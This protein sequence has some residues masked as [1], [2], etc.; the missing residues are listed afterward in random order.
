MVGFSIEREENIMEI[1]IC[2]NIKYLRKKAKMTQEELALEMG[3]SRQSLAKWENGESL[4]DVMNCVK[5]SE[6]FDISID[7]LLNFSI[8]K[9]EET[10]GSTNG[11]Y[12]FGITSLSDDGT[13]TLPE[14]ARQVFGINKGDTLVVMGDTAK[15]GIALAKIMGKGI[16]GGKR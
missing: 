8:E 2:E 10:D 5:I 15:G 14:N 7:M 13:V 4:P 9:N 12:I 11:K 3:V 1:F 16:L 6:L